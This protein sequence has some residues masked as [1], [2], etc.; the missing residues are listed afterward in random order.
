MTRYAILGPLLVERDGREVGL[1][2]NLQRALLALLVT[3][4]GRTGSVDRITDELWGDDARR[5]R[6]LDPDVRLPVAPPA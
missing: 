3:E 4:R 1:G 5:P 6:G 2:S